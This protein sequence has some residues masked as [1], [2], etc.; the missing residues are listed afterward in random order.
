M[1]NA[2]GE[3]D[4]PTSP[5]YSKVDICRVQKMLLEMG[6]T[7]CGILDRHNVPYFITFGT[8]LGAVRHGGFIPWDDD[9]DIFLF[10]ESYDKAIRCLEDELPRHLIVHGPKTDPIYFPA[11]SSVKN[12]LTEV[13]DSGLYNP[14][15][16]LLRYKCIGVDMYRIKKIGAHQVRSY[17]MR[18]AMMFF[19]RKHA[20]GI[21]S[22]EIY[23]EKA[24]LLSKE[25]S[26]AEEEEY[27]AKNKSPVYM[28]ML[29]LKK[30]I[31]TDQLFPLRKYSF[32]DTEFWGPADSDALLSSIY[33]DYMCIP[34]FDNRRSHFKRVV[35]L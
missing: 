14:D 15:N 4:F 9:F 21:I 2:T 25:L 7:V 20:F 19:S 33:G 24:K 12:K 17:K 28:F 29:L 26:E 10:D 16:N 34:D 1:K 5:E 13:V 22:D 31:S 6:K 11:W 32:E 18:E 35:F 30:A 23:R 27:R 3:L 8:L